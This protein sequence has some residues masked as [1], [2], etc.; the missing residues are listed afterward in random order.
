MIYI[1]NITNCWLYVNVSL[2]WQWSLW[3]YFWRSKSNINLSFLALQ[4]LSSTCVFPPIH[5]NIFLISWACYLVFLFSSL[6]PFW[7]ILLLLL[8]WLHKER[9]PYMIYEVF[10]P[11]LYASIS[12]WRTQWHRR[13]CPNSHLCIYLVWDIH[14]DV[15]A[16]ALSYLT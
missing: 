2:H 13:I 15:I 4:Y 7:F 10:M 5:H 9:Q 1:K 16:S 3:R 11:D 12:I 6:Y 8:H 14:C